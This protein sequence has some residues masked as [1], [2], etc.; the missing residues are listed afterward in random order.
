MSKPEEESKVAAPVEAPAEP[1]A[2]PAAE[3]SKLELTPLAAQPAKVQTAAFKLITDSQAQRQNLINNSMLFSMPTISA[4]VATLAA[5]VAAYFRYYRD[6]GMLVLAFG[7]VTI[8]FLSLVA[9]TTEIEVKK[10]EKIKYE[11]VLGPRSKAAVYVYNDTAVGVVAA[12]QEEQQKRTGGTL[13]ITGWSTLRRYRNTGMGSDL[14]EWLLKENKWAKITVSTH[15][16]EKAA[17]HILKKNGFKVVNT[18]L[19]AGVRG[20]IFGQAEY[21][22]ELEA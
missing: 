19:D 2:K 11:D 17:E 21:D 14:L 10:A 16:S 22:W 15:S 6:T 20:N 9:R 5:V 3:P 4:Y 13:R 8:A 7:G 1:A 18:R 12:V